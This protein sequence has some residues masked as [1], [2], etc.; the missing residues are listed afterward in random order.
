[1]PVISVKDIML[2]LMRLLQDLYRVD[3]L[4]D[5]YKVVRLQVLFRV[6]CLE[7]ECRRIS[8]KTINRLTVQAR[9]LKLR[10]VKMLRQPRSG[11]CPV[12]HL[13]VYKPM[14]VL[15][16]PEQAVRPVFPVLQVDPVVL[17][18]QVGI[19]L[20]TLVLDNILVEPLVNS[21]KTVIGM[22]KVKPEKVK[23]ETVRLLEQS[24]EQAL[25]DK[26]LVVQASP[27]LALV[28]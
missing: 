13:G 4:V 1:M 12:K 11:I 25:V 26:V 22:P 23:L 9:M 10:L 7:Q 14:V 6:M 3:L 2:V 8:R 27:E 19:L 17:N 5:P 21:V 15:V 20:E 24:P 18:G 28:A 16:N